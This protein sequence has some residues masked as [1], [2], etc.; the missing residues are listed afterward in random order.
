MK[1]PVIASIAALLAL[2]FSACHQQAGAEEGNTAGEESETL[3]ALSAEQMQL[4]GIELGRPDTLAMEAFI[5]C[6]G[7][8]DL[9]PTQVYSVHSPVMGFVQQVRHY[10]GQYVRQGE[11]L[12]S[13]SH[14]ELMRLQRSFL[15]SAARLTFL[16][17][18]QERSS[19]L[20]Q[21]DA[22]SPKAAEQA[23]ADYEVE[24]ASFEGLKME[25]KWMGINVEEVVRSKKAQEI[26]RIYAPAKGYITKMEINPGKLVEPNA[27]MYELADNSHQH[28]ELQVYA[29]D[30]ARIR[31]GQAVLA[32]LPGSDKPLAGKVFL[33][34]KTIDA[35]T[36]TANIHV[37]FDQEPLG[38]AIGTYLS[39]RILT[40]AD[41]MLAV[42]ES[43][44]VR[45]D[46]L[47]FV[48]VKEND[49]FRKQLITVGRTEGGYVAIEG[50]KLAEGQQMV[51]KGAYYL[52]QGE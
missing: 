38:L 7:F 14:P 33:I 5:E 27:L 40:K 22:A 46:G 9:P 50:L 13:I 1:Y 29:K 4:A 45:S 34:G 41:E 17:R 30:L 23:Q 51:L 43:A 52:N 31:E 8:T 15:E 26:I 12:T 39:A 18:Q 21:A 24:K 36:K 44:I 25:L 47:A 3:I 28:L 10:P 6:A 37:H 11:L 35:N 20:A 42:P 16:Q 49:G 19:E 48:F 32:Y 2:S